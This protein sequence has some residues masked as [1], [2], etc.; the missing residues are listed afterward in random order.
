MKNVHLTLV[1]GSLILIFLASAAAGE[2]MAVAL[3][4]PDFRAI[5]EILKPAGRRKHKGIVAKWEQISQRGGELLLKERDLAVVVIDSKGNWFYRTSG[6]HILRSLYSE[7]ETR[8]VEDLVD[9]RVILD[10]PW[11]QQLRNFY[12][13][14]LFAE[15]SLIAPAELA[16]L[17]RRIDKLPD[18]ELEQKDWFR[19][20]VGAEIRAMDN[21]ARKNL[22]LDPTYGKDFINAIAIA[23]S[24]H[25][26]Q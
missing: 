17:L 11:F 21:T 18:P 14:L 23:E 8:D 7:S 15:G 25:S 19:G 5:R 3:Y 13:T 22:L 16:L 2:E 4:Y 6:I 24:A 1:L 10:D 20:I 12:D 9:I 26:Q